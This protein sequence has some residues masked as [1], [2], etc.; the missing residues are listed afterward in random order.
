M[1][2]KNPELIDNSNKCKKTGMGRGLSKCKNRGISEKQNHINLLELL[3]ITYAM[4][5]VLPET[6]VK[7]N[8]SNSDRQQ[9][10][11]D[12]YK[13]NGGTVSSPCNQ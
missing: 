12:I 10:S 4:K 8:S 2:E 3:A 1:D 5:Q 9:N 6:E 11:Y 7:S 13:Y